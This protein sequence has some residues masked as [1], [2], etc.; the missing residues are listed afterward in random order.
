MLGTNASRPSDLEGLRL[1]NA[2]GTLI[3]DFRADGVYDTNVICVPSVLGKAMSLVVGA[4]VAVVL[5]VRALR[6]AP[7]TLEAGLGRVAKAVG[8]GCI[9]TTVGFVVTWLV[10]AVASSVVTCGP[11]VSARVPYDYIDVTHE[12]FSI[13]MN[14]LKASPEYVDKTAKGDMVYGR[15]TFPGYAVP[16]KVGEKG[17]VTLTIYQTSALM[18]FVA[19]LVYGFS[20]VPA[21]VTSSGN[22]TTMGYEV[23]V[24][25]LP[26]N[27]G[28][29][30]A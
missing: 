23:T 6:P 19:R 13:G 2:N 29:V 24:A 12:H 28:M 4:V 11:A 30:W 18:A 15:V 10:N 9:T 3:L 7:D 21:Y 17:F 25:Q 1:I 16:T 22:V 27:G 26:H 20:A 14:L 8:V 5:A